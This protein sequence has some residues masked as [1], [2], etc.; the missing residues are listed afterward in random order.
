[1]PNYASE[2]LT[3][4][5][6][7]AIVNAQTRFA[8]LTPG[9]S[10]AMLRSAANTS[11]P[12]SAITPTCVVG[13]V[14]PFVACSF[15]SDPLTDCTRIAGA[16]ALVNCVQVMAGIVT[17]SFR[18]MIVSF[19]NGHLATRTN[20]DSTY[21]AGFEGMTS[22]TG[23]FTPSIVSTSDVLGAIVTPWFANE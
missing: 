3:D 12:A 23:Q 17:L 20:H 18:A 8:P 10:C 13:A 1:M 16:F 9:Q 6:D 7:A 22:C 11:P 19:R 15:I 21:P 4:A 14:V 5:T 2:W